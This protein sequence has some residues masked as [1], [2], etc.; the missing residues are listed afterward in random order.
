MF[1]AEWLERLS[2]VP[3]FI[4]YVLWGPV[5]VVL[6]LRADFL[7]RWAVAGLMS[8]T[9]FEY[10]LHRFVL[11]REFRFEGG[12]RLHFLIHGVHHADPMD[13]GRLVMPWVGA[14][15]FATVL[16]PAFWLVLG[17]WR[18]PSFAAGFLWGYLAYE[19]IH[20]TIHQ[21]PAR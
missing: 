10:A 16:L 19:A 18:A 3:P 5:S 20:Y 11:H 1:E 21:R 17:A 9:L 12:A 15:S 4:P 8:W 6:L 14:F 13:R 2:Y 7:P